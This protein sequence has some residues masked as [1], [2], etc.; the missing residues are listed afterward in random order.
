MWFVQFLKRKNE[1][2]WMTDWRLEAFRVWSK[3]EEPEWANVSYKKTGVSRNCLL[4]C[5]KTKT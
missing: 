4:F 1:P 5:S 2:K 3:M